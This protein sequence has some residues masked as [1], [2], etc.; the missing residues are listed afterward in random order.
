GM[1][2][3]RQQIE[4]ADLILHVADGTEALMEDAIFPNGAQAKSSTLLVL[5]KSDL[6]GHE[7]WLGRDAIRISCKTGAGLDA[8]ADA[9]ESRILGGAAQRDWTVAINARHQACL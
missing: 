8:L 3:T 4:R 7:S 1:D 9:I 5:N 6:A 2:R